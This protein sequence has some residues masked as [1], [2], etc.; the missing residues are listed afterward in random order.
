[1]NRLYRL[2]IPVLGLTGCTGVFHSTQPALQLY[3]LPAPAASGTAS[4]SGPSLRIARPVM[5]PGLDTD[6]IALLRS[7]NR[8]DYF[9]GSRWSAPLADV[10]S[11]L[12]LAVFRTGS[13]WGAVADDR[14]VLNAD[15]LLQTQVEHFTAEYA[16]DAGTPQVRIELQCLL[17]RRSDSALLGSFVVTETQLAG[18][19]H[20][21]S[22]VAAFSV[23]ID[24]ALG[25][26]VEHTDQLLRA[27]K[28]PADR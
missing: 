21:A 2:L 25:A 17:I 5:A 3:E 8:L 26:A 7:G 14:T 4:G 18:E 15:Y 19:N 20:M 23:A 6:R 13:A 22:V 1:M 12:E 10:V 27:A 9:A 24:R 11:D 28:S 16:T